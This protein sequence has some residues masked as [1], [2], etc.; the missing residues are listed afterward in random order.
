MPLMVCTRC[1]EFNPEK[2]IEPISD[3]QA[4]AEC[5]ACGARL[6]FL[7]LPMFAVTGASGVGKTTVMHALLQ[8]NLP[9]VVLEGDMLWGRVI[10]SN[11]GS[12]DAYFSTWLRVIAGIHQSGRSVVFCGTLL[13]EQVEHLVERRYI[14][15]IH[16]ISLIDDDDRIRMR[17]KAR[18]G[19]RESGDD[20]WIRSQV[21]FNDWLVQHGSSLAA[22]G[23]VLDTAD[24]TVES[25]ADRIASFI[26]ARVNPL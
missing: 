8:R 10:P 15:P 6:P 23:L 18:P 3:T 12:H 13:S 1:G 25:V 9:A 22:D 11:D 20:A 2:Q 24:Q 7:R 17:L 5:P 21:E 19:W 4:I 26:T 16:Y 14:G